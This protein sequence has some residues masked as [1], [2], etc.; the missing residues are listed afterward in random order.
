M[1]KH[2]NYDISMCINES[3]NKL[4]AV[5]HFTYLHTPL[6]A[7]YIPLKIVIATLEKNSRMQFYARKTA[8]LK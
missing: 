3:I 2:D 1:C 6:G 7:M 4:L 5:E 8:F